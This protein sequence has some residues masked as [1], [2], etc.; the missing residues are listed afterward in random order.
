MSKKT[1]RA[2]ILVTS[3]ILL[4]VLCPS[5]EAKII[6]VDNNAA[7]LND[8]SS[9]MS[10]YVYL[11]DALAD[12]SSTEEP[13]E[14]RVAQG[15][16]KPDEG[17]GV[18]R[19]DREATFQ[20]INGVTLKGGYGGSTETDPNTRDIELYKTI[21]SGDLNDDDA[22]VVFPPNLLAEPTR[23]ENSYHVVTGSGTD[24][25]AMLDGF[26]ITGGNASRDEWQANSSGGGMNNYSGRPTVAYCIFTGNSAVRYGGGIYNYLDSN[27]KIANCVF[28][29][30]SASDG[31]GV[32]DENSSPMLSNCTFMG[33]RA[34]W[35]AG[36]M[37]NLLSIATIVSCIL[38]DN[39]APQITGDTLVSYSDVQG[40]WPGAGNIDA[41]PLLAEP[42]YWVDADDPNIAVE[43]NDPHVI[44]VDGD[45]HLKS[46]AGRWDPNSRSWVKDDVTSPCVDTGDPNSDWSGETWPH[47]ERINMGAYGG[48]REASMSIRPETMFLPHVAYIRNS[49]SQAAQSYQSLLAS[50]GCTTDLIN[51]DTVGAMSL[52]SYDLVIV[53][54][55]TGFTSK[56]GDDQAVAAVESSGKPVL[57]L[58]EGG[59]AFFGNLG[60]SIGY[61]NGGH[62][63]RNSIYVIDPNNLLFS[64]PYG[65]DMPE[66]QVLQ[67]YT[68]AAH[69]GLYLWP[70]PETVT[71]LGGEVDNP[72]YYPLVLEQNQYMFWGFD[73]SPEKM[74]EVGR[75]LFVNVVIRTANKAW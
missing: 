51:L 35:G 41:D 32:C 45:Y 66:D 39:T 21:L 11:Q 40:G 15:I 27:P 22:E 59:Y 75:T 23:A 56:W 38:W 9:W 50:Y 16:Y 2:T 34:D 26:T 37:S 54:T 46:Q 17:T 43:P 52:D 20:L 49:N 73:A 18:A 55:D 24:E 74:T 53:G 13:V 31:G 12:A 61:P 72:G 14:V 42:G 63:N 10:A 29:A 67:L 5:S 28:I 71:A 64:T 70:V 44:W 58:G 47:G 4:S 3:I 7:G 57:G 60:L 48:T 62:G 8:G 19:G 36:A 1:K 69:V 33:N 30:N 25:T 65:I 6:Y 68:E